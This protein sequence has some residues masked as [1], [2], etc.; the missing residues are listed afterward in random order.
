MLNRSDDNWVINNLSYGYILDVNGYSFGFET[1]EKLLEKLTN[2][3]TDP[4][5]VSKEIK[6][7]LKLKTRLF[8]DQPDDRSKYSTDDMRLNMRDVNISELSS[9]YLV[10]VGC[11]AFVFE[12]IDTMLEKLTNYIKNPGITEYN[13]MENKTV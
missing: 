7:N 1:K 5:L 12:S 10:R 3:I 9:G 8:S 13:W 11:Q 4:S 6:E 2:Y